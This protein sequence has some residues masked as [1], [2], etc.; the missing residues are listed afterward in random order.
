MLEEDLAAHVAPEN[1]L[2]QGATG[3]AGEHRLRGIQHGLVEEH[4]D[5][6][7]G[8]RHIVGRVS[9]PPCLVVGAAEQLL[10]M[11]PERIG[12][13]RDLTAGAQPRDGGEDLLQGERELPAAS[14]ASIFGWGSIGGWRSRGHASLEPRQTDWVEEG[15]ADRVRS[16]R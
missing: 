15:G 3:P 13:R 10:H 6:V 16:A 4:D 5:R 8:Q 1:L 11:G 9:H 12:V 7:E 14:G 2:L